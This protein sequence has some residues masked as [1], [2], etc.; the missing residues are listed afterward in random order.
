MQDATLKRFQQFK[1]MFVSANIPSAVLLELIEDYIK[2]DGDDITIGETL[3]L[4]GQ[5]SLFDAA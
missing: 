3:I 1:A 5:M 2:S 4:D